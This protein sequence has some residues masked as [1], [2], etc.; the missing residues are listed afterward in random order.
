MKPYKAQFY[1]YADS[2]QE[3]MELEKALHDFTAA[4]YGKGVLVSATKITEAVR[5]FGHNLLI[6]QFLK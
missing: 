5:R 1:V 3:V 4:Q 6:T 2:E